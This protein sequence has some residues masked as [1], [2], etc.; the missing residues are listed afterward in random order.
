LSAANVG[1]WAGTGSSFREAAQLLAQLSDNA[2]LIESKRVQI[3]DL[4]SQDLL[5]VLPTVSR[6][7][8]L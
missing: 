7:S 6:A 5:T 8:G 3:Q 1:S 4:A 2:C